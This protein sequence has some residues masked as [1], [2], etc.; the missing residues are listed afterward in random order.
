MGLLLELGADPNQA[1]TGLSCTALHLAASNEFL[2]IIDLLLKYGANP[3]CEDPRGF[4]LYCTV[5]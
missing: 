5:C 3:D 2:G 4:T 1:H